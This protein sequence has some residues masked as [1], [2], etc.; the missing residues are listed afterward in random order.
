MSTATAGRVRRS[1]RFAQLNAEM[2]AAPQDS[3]LRRERFS[4]TDR[5][6][7]PSFQNTQDWT[8]GM[9]ISPSGR[10]QVIEEPRGRQHAFSREG[11]RKDWARGIT[12]VLTAALCVLLLVGLASL[13]ASSI[14]MQ[15]LETRIAAAEAKGE[16]LR[17][18]LQ[19]LSGDISVC[20]KAVEL[21]LIS[22]NGAPT[23]SLTAP[24]GATMTLVETSVAT[25]TQEP[26]IRAAMGNAE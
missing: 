24:A 2:G 26:E 16:T 8:G 10:F 18:D 19:Q 4:G 6:E 17:A 7:M 1:I 14:R 23:I 13:G 9:G 5:L 12:W 15:K 25:A 21:N 20:T 22:S 3:S 11:V